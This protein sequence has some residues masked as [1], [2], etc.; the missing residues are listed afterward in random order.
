MNRTL[1]QRNRYLH[2]STF[3]QIIHCKKLWTKYIWETNFSSKCTKFLD[4]VF[5]NFVISAVLD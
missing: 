4:A 1:V 5:G 3:G 2:K